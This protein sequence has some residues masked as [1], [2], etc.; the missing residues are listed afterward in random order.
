MTNTRSVSSDLVYRGKDAPLL[1]AIMY[2]EWQY[3]YMY[4]KNPGTNYADHDAIQAGLKATNF[5]TSEAAAFRD[6]WLKCA[7]L[8]NERVK[9]V[10]A[11]F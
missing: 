7:E 8:I 2:D 3:Y 1:G 5:T 10:F 4:W 11:D 9:S 6:G